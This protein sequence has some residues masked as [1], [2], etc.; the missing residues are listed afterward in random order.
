MRHLDL[1]EL[2]A[3]L[4]EIRQSPPDQGTLAL[5]VVRPATDERV[6]LT[7]CHLS[8]ELGAKGDNWSLGCWKSL[9]DGSPHPDVQLAIMNARAIALIAQETERWPLAGDNLFFDLDLSR[10]NLPAG[11]R[12]GVGSAVLEITKVAHN[13]C[14]KFAARYG[15]DAVTFVNSIEGK[16]LRLR[17]VYARVVQAG[18]VKVGDVIRKILE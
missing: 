14:H 8:P 2:E 13:G 18:T 7:E 3:G 9:P 5:C 12:L 10:Q 11:Q 4:A 16:W 1:A 15:P 6:T 17:G